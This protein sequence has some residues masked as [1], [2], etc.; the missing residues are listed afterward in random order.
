MQEPVVFITGPTAA[1][2][3]DLA[4]DW[5]GRGPAGLINSDSIQAYKDLNKGSAKPD[6]AR[7]AGLDFYLFNEVSAPEIWTAGAF[8]RKAL[9][10][11]NHWPKGKKA[12]V[13]GGS[14]FYLQ[15]LEKGMYPAPA[16]IER[17]KSALRAL[18]QKE[19]EQ[20]P[21]SLYQL[22]RERDPET[23][24]RIA[25]KDLYRIKRAL[26]LI[27]SGGGKPSQI[28]R[29]FKEQALPWRYV[30]L[31]LRISKDQ[32]LKRVEQRAKNM[33]SQGLLEEVEQLL[34]RGLAQWPPLDCAGY[35][36]ARLFIEGRLKR[37]ELLPAIVGRTMALA[38]K[39]K[40]WAKRD[41]SIQWFDF[42]EKPLAIYKKIFKR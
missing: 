30:K 16:S 38:K 14:G 19:R 8:R 33:L 42:N 25:P 34:K 39:Q 40:T 6:F 1:G 29:E 37:E 22:L 35:R 10:L 32:L 18:L 36:E 3:T 5:A 27:E 20:G 31:G 41:R 4:I 26:A 28:R 15:A 7:H 11:L 9:Q 17:E 2:K 21:A 13:V 12:F 23:A 24:S